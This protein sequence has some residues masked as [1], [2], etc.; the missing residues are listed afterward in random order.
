M[1]R[2]IIYATIGLILLGAISITI[3]KVLFP[4]TPPY[5]PPP[6]MA[7]PKP[8][9]DCSPPS[10]AGLTPIASLNPSVKGGLFQTTTATLKAGITIKLRS[11]LVIIADDL[12]SIEGTITIDPIPSTTP[13]PIH[14]ILY[15]NN[16][17]IWV[18]GEITGA[19]P[20]S[21]PPPYSGQEDRSTVSKVA[22][23][24]G[25][26]E[27]GGVVKVVSAQSAIGIS[28]RILG[29]DGGWGG[30]AVA[31]PA[32]SPGTAVAVGGQGGT[33]GDVLLCAYDSID[34][35]GGIVGGGGGWG[36][37]AIAVGEYGDNAWGVGGPGNVSG[38]IIFHGLHKD[39]R[40]MNSSGV[41]GG[42]GG[43]GGSAEALQGKKLS[44]QGGEANAQGGEGGQGGTVKFINCRSSRQGYVDAGNGG[45][46]GYSEAIGGDGENIS[47]SW[48][49]Y[50][51]GK[52]LISFITRGYSGG[53]AT[54]TGG[55]GGKAGTTPKIPI[56][57]SGTAQG[58]PGSGGYGGLA[59]ATQGSG[60]DGWP[61]GWTGTATAQGGIGG[62]TGQQPPAKVLAPTPG[63][64][65]TSTKPGLGGLG[66]YIFCQGGH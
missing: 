43:A 59:S 17:P 60:G 3:W 45:T 53:D 58:S 16:G 33:G 1:G 22:A 8:K 29:F 56:M 35:D 52:S 23:G 24:S 40:V 10:T 66:D 11:T 21:Q 44:K 34:F 25:P 28:G 48:S 14:I 36:G 6:R 7:S 13:K 61:G 49:S 30:K 32:S 20:T 9:H 19:M 4:T 31:H 12:I 47:G 5:I 55:S 54:S 42:E 37:R 2:K 27:H 65:G 46:G 50:I 15:C 41:Y 39:A 51:I 64:P 38:D 26:G 63:Q 18:S 57:P 62:D